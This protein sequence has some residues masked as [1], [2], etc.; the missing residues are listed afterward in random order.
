MQSNARIGNKT[1][2]GRDLVREI[3]CSAESEGGRYA[4]WVCPRATPDCECGLHTSVNYQWE[5]DF[6][7]EIKNF[8]VN[9]RT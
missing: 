4:S 5:S 1:P 2:S 6:R 7:E 8:V 3:D 9:W